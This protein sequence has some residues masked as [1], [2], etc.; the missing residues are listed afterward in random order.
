MAPGGL[1]VRSTCATVRIGRVGP[2]YPLPPFFTF[3]GNSIG[4]ILAELSV[5]QAFFD[6]GRRD[7]E[8]YG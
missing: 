4:H 6:T 2:A 8:G 3:L 5:F 1:A 7:G